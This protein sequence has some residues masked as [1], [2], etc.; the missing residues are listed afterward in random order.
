M[1]LVSSAG[2][3]TCDAA[4][5][6]F[7]VSPVV[8]DEPSVER[9]NVSVV[10][11]GNSARALASYLSFRG[12]TVKLLVRSLDT[13]SDIRQQGHIIASGKIEGRF[14]ID[15]VTTD[16]DSGIDNSTTIFIATVTT[17]YEEIACR[18]APYLK[19]GQQVVLFSSKFGG[20]VHFAKVL[21]DCGAPG[22]PVME[23][24]ALFACRTQDDGSIWIR[25][26]KQWTLFSAPTQSMTLKNKNSIFRFFPHLQMADN[27][28]QRGLTDFGALTHALTMLV[29]MNTIDRGNSFPFY[30]EG[31]TE[32][33]VVLLE[34]MESEFR[35]VAEA[36]GTT[37]IPM[38]ELLNRYYGC[39]TT[40]LLTAMRS[41]PNY[42]LSQSPPSL[43]HRYIEEDVSCSLVPIR[44][45]AVRA[46]IKTP[47]VD[48]VIN[49]ASAVLGEDFNST[50]RTLDKLG[51]G[52]MTYDQ[53]KQSINA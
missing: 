32:R 15:S 11:S 3:T 44:Q 41:V 37:L 26:F 27:V 40:S 49:L 2:L 42:R 17:A 50:G 46:G 24:D 34:K 10:G 12:H 7:C 48:T 25:G 23:T 8:H 13:S 20:V 1:S 47:I 43:Q 52:L 45:L 39:D 16:P 30:L 51:W 21:A 38:T 31:F 19:C 28:V 33:T 18:L 4:S 9:E 36:Y 6:D 29:N 5:R 14:P 35:A 53:I 22:V